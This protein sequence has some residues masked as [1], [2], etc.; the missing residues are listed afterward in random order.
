MKAVPMLLL[1]Q[2]LRNPRT[3]WAAQ[4]V[5]IMLVLHL[6]Q[7]L[8]SFMSFVV[9]AH[10][11]MSFVVVAHALMSFVV[12]AHALSTIS[13]NFHT[14]LF[15][16]LMMLLVLMFVLLLVLV[17]LLWCILRYIRWWCS[18]LHRII[19]LYCILRLWAVHLMAEFSVDPPLEC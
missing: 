8:M 4:L 6:F 3:A 16:L 10:A 7:V 18:T 19:G 11:L 13:I 1:I 9:V 12:V 5:M 17:Y 14:E 2:L 15:V